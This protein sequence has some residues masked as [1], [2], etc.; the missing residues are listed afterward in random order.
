M[1]WKTREFHRVDLVTFG[2]HATEEAF[3]AKYQSA[4]FDIQG[5]SRAIAVHGVPIDG[6]AT[7]G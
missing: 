7:G 6:S 1:K 3:H 5:C 2:Y 4:A